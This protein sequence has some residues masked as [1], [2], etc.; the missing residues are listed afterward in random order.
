MEGKILPRAS[1]LSLLSFN[2]T[3]YKGIHGVRQSGGAC[4]HIII[5]EAAGIALSLTSAYNP[6]SP[7]LPH[8]NPLPL[9]RL[10]AVH[11]RCTADSSEATGFPGFLFSTGAYAMAIRQAAILTTRVFI[12][13]SVCSHS[14]CTGC[15]PVRTNASSAINAPCASLLRS[16]EASHQAHGESSRRVKSYTSSGRAIACE[17]D[18]VIEAI[19]GGWRRIGCLTSTRPLVETFSMT[20]PQSPRKPPT[21]STSGF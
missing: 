18:G 14:R 8:P 13:F 10:F 2:R 11:D 4:T 3:I 5:R 7:S 9:H 20:S 1:A 17:T 21:I 15:R 19:N 16:L 12:P 6:A